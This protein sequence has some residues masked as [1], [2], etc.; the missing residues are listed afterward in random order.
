MKEVLTNLTSL[1]LPIKSTG[2]DK[3]VAENNGLFSIIV[4]RCS[5]FFNYSYYDAVTETF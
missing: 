3:L 5:S 1:N 2:S 4:T